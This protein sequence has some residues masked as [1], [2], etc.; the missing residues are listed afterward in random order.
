MRK[1]L[2]KRMLNYRKRLRDAGMRPVQIWVPDIRSPGFSDE[3][4]HQSLL[5]SKSDS[6]GETIKQLDV[7]KLGRSCWHHSASKIVPI[8]RQVHP[9]T[10]CLYDTHIEELKKEGSIP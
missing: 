5:V 7:W 10:D 2:A 6:E 8:S 3:A 4:R 9:V 1:T